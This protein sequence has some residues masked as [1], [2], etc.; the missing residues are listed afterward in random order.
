LQ[1]YVVANEIEAAAKKKAILLSVLGAETHQLMRSL[2]AP[3]KPTEKSYD[4]L[5]DLVIKY[6]QPM[7]SVILQ[8]FKFGSQRV[9]QSLHLFQS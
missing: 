7:P 3:Q 6:Y 4:Q 5:V 9:N 2:A 1:E 8:H